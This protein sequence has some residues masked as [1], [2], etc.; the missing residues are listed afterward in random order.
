[1]R[2]ASASGLQAGDDATN[3]SAGRRCASRTGEELEDD[4]PVEAHA[5]HPLTQLPARAK[6]STRFG[7]PRK[8]RSCDPLP[9]GEGPT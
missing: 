7:K 3:A 9:T 4:E 1:M 8:G 2:G 6:E 5:L